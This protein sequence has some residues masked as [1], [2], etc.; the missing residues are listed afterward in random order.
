LQFPLRDQEG[1]PFMAIKAAGVF[2]QRLIAPLADI[3]KDRRDGL[4][5]FREADGFARREGFEGGTGNDSQHVYITILLRGYS[6]MP[7]APASFRRGM[8]TRT[9]DSSRMV[10]TASHSPSLRGDM[11]GFFSAGRTFS[12]AVRSAVRTLS[13]SPT[14]P[15]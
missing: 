2:E 15:R 14:F 4:L 9:V 7:C 8:I 3:G 10:F 12:T 6:T 5:G 11:V 13:M 1:G